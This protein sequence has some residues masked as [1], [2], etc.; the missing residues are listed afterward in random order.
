MSKIKKTN[1]LI[2]KP[3]NQL[4]SEEKIT[5]EDELPFIKIGRFKVSYTP[6]ENQIINDRTMILAR[7]IA[8]NM[9]EAENY[10]VNVL[11]FQQAV[12]TSKEVPNEYNI[13]LNIYNDETINELTC[14]V[15]NSRTDNQDYDKIGRASVGKECVR[16]CRS[17]WSPYH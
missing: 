3:K 8:N 4:L 12:D 9:I 7:Q 17:R 10:F 13:T 2:T 5:N 11:G 1:C 15:L 6:S 14:N 16:R